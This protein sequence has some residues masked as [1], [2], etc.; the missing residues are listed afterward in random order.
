MIKSGELIQL[1][2]HWLYCGDARTTNLDWKVDLVFTD[3][4]FE[5]GASDVRSAIE[6]FADQFVVSGHGINY[7]KLCV[8]KGLRYHFEIV[9]QRSK[10]QSVPNR[11]GPQILHWNTAFL[12]KGS[13]NCFDRELA[14]NYFPSVLGPYKS[15]L[16]GDYAKPLQWAIDI[17]KVFHAQTIVDP[18]LGTGTT[19]I[20]CE[21]LG[22]T[23]F[24]IEINPRLCELAID[25]FH[26]PTT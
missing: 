11:N 19:L 4:P 7:H 22:K 26:Q 16:S 15:Q 17:L 25:R 24:G 5:M 2:R 18:F 3:P 20:A 10:P 9:T 14:N 13:E 6:P 1:G 23:C 12:S 21:K 8:L